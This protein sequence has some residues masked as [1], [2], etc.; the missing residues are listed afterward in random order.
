[1]SHDEIEKIAQSIMDGNAIIDCPPAA[2]ALACAKL[3]AYA[4]KLEE[5]G[6]EQR[7]PEWHNER[8]ERF[9]G[10][11]MGTIEGVN[12]YQTV[13][14]IIMERLG[15]SPFEDKIPCL[16][17]T[18][19]EDLAQAWCEYYFDTQIVGASSFVLGPGPTCYSPDGLSIVTRNEP[20][21]MIMTETADGVSYTQSTQR[22]TRLV[23]WE[24][25]C[26]FMR[27]PRGQ[28]PVYY[29][30]QPKLGMEILLPNWSIFAECVFRRCKWDDCA[31]T[32]TCDRELAPTRSGTLRACG[33]IE[34]RG[35]DPALDAKLSALFGGKSIYDLGAVPKA[36]IQDAL[37][38]FGAGRIKPIYHKFT[39]FIAPPGGYLETATISQRCDDMLDAVM[40]SAESS[41]APL[42]CVL[43]WKLFA[44]EA[45]D[46]PREVGFLDKKMPELE[47]IL[48]I[49][50]GAQQL[51]RHEHAEYVDKMLKA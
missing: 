34:F 3:V 24:F 4:R 21:A 19:F 13:R 16:Y 25:K 32:Y 30:G 20:G 1:M 23:L 36:V 50:K 41:P 11:S 40:D 47:R 5:N 38:S 37:F 22:I 48:G 7:S 27:L 12:P 14:D 46:L 26:M 29:V 8:A 33:V 49:I 10:S 17:G 18:L 44:V 39:P 31:P 9:G 15:H 28:I 42:T 35:D 51:P 2:I 6:I 43:P 45:Y